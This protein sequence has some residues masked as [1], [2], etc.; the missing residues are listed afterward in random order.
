VRPTGPG[1]H[2]SLNSSRSRIDDPFVNRV[3]KRH[4]VRESA[5]TRVPTEVCERRND[6][7]DGESF[8]SLAADESL[9]GLEDTLQGIAAALL[10]GSLDHVH[11]LSHAGDSIIGQ[12]AKKVSAR[13]L[14]IES[15]FYI[16]ATVAGPP[17]AP[18]PSGVRRTMTPPL[19]EC[20]SPRKGA[21]HVGTS[22][23]N[24][25]PAFFRSPCTSPSLVP[26][27]SRPRSVRPSARA[28]RP[29]NSSIPVARPQPRTGSPA[30]PVR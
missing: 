5:A 9:G 4:L 8:V 12:P 25:V 2:G 17:S 24:P 16:L 18:A 3:E 23:S 21:R 19:A 26:A 28:E 1:R 6:F 27:A 14:T 22:Q 29:R 20:S 10:T 13:P 30:P 15:R 11:R 7:R